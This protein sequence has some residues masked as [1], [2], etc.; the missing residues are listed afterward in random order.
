MKIVDFSLFLY[1]LRYSLYI[2]VPVEIRKILASVKAPAI[3]Q[4]VLRGILSQYA[5]QHDFSIPG[6]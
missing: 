3:E 6:L 5:P 2:L 1:L 4:I